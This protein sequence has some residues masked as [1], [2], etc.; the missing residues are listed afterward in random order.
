MPKCTTCTACMRLVMVLVA[1]VT[2]VCQ[3]GTCMHP[4]EAAA[5]LLPRRSVLFKE[6]TV[7]GLC[8]FRLI[9]LH[10]CRQNLQGEGEGGQAL[11][12]VSA[13]FAAQHTATSSG[14]LQRAT[15]SCRSV[16]LTQP[17]SLLPM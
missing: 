11:R 12:R 6:A 4:Y 10:A 15:C 3:T 14:S 1:V 17:P 9:Y 2:L 8:S 7:D 13:S 5:A 16:L